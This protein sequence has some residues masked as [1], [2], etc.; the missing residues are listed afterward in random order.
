MAIAREGRRMRSP[1][2]RMIALCVDAD[3]FWAQRNA[4]HG[5]IKTFL[6]PII[7]TTHLRAT[8]SNANGDYSCC[9]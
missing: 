1:A 4:R 9:R 2:L 8:R 7:I 5:F 3:K 6:N